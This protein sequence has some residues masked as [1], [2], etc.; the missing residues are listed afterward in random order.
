MLLKNWKRF[1]TRATK[2]REIGFATNNSV[3]AL[4]LEAYLF[5]TVSALI[6]NEMSV[7][8]QLQTKCASFWADFDQ[9][10]KKNVSVTRILIC[11]CSDT[12]FQ[13]KNR[14]GIR[15]FDYWETCLISELKCVTISKPECP[16]F[17][18]FPNWIS[19]WWK[20][21]KF[22][23][24]NSGKVGHF[25]LPIRLQTTS[26]VFSKKQEKLNCLSDDLSYLYTW[27]K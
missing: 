7:T 21:I 27:L 3:F 19:T 24:D 16:I 1:Y 14:D 11:C 9:I 2:Q 12:P 4:C 8:C 20:K 26:N 23:P 5:M 13:H 17:K 18:V 6:F 15:Y 10:K 25:C 22:Q